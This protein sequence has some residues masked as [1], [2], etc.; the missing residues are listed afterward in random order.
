MDL[1]LLSAI[2]WWQPVPRWYNIHVG[3]TDYIDGSAFQEECAP[4][5]QTTAKTACRLELTLLS[6]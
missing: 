1:L 2:D 5:L 6:K 3:M 4:Q